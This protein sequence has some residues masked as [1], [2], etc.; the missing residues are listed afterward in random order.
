LYLRIHSRN[1]LFN[2]G[3]HTEGFNKEP[4]WETR[5]LWFCTGDENLHYFLEKDNDINRDIKRKSNV[6]KQSCLYLCNLEEVKS[7]YKV[8]EN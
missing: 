2:D 6:K 3:Y 5:N 1:I 8:E 4:L 7:K